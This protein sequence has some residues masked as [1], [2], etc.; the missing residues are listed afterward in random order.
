MKKENVIES[1][2]MEAKENGTNDVVEN[3]AVETKEMAVVENQNTIMSF[4][5]MKRNSNT[6]AR[7]YTNIKDKKQLFNL[8]SKVDFL[9]NDCEGEMIRVKG[10]LIKI[11]NK[12]LK[13]PIIDEETGEIVKEF[14]TSMSCT[15]IDDNGK[16]YATGSK[17]FAIQLMRYIQNYDGMTQIDGEG[18]EIKII[19]RKAGEK[20]NK[21]LAFELV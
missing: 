21:A 15:L 8:E 6:K 13:E 16:S 7:I 2:V 14:E 12:P 20:G 17:M 1:E 3:E 10:V 18:L 11:F 5:D 4:D 9:L 19:K